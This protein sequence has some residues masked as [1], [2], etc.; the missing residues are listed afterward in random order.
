[1]NAAQGNWIPVGDR[2]PKKG[3]EVLIFSGGFMTVG[4]VNAAGYWKAI[5]VIVPCE[6][7]MPLPEPPEQP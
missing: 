6:F 4:C 5:G 1:M 2:L 3:T 7:W